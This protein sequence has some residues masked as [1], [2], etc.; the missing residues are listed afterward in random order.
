M[1]FSLGSTTVGFMECSYLL[2]DVIKTEERG[3]LT[4]P[5]KRDQIMSLATELMRHK[6]LY[7]RGTPEISD[8]A[9][10]S[11]EMKL[12]KLS[13]NHPVLSFVGTDSPITTKKVSHGKAMLSLQKTYDLHD[14]RA[15]IGQ[16]AVVGTWKIDGNSLSLVYQQGK[17]VLA[18]TRG[19]GKFGE[20]V[21]DKIRWVAD[22]IPT[23]PDKLDIEIRGELYCSAE[24]FHLLAKEMTDLGM[25]KPTHPRNI[26]SGMLGRKNDYHLARYFN[27]QAFELIDETDSLVLESEMMCFRWLQ[28]QGFR[29]PGVQLLINQEATSIYLNQVRHL[30]TTGDI[31]IDGAVFSINDR[32]LHQKLGYTAHHPRYKMVFK[33]QGETAISTIE[34]IEWSTSRLGIVTPV[35]VIKPVFLSGAKIKNITLHNAQHIINF[36]LKPGDQIE[37]VRSGEVIPKFLRV[38]KS[39][40]GKHQLP[41]ACPS[42]QNTLHFDGIRLKCLNDHCPA[43][44]TGE[45]LNWIKAVEIDDLSEKRLQHLLDRKLI[46]NIPDLYRLTESDF[47]KLPLTKEKM[48]RKLVSAIAKSRNLPLVHFLNGL[49]FEGMG[50]TS[51]LALLKAFPTLTELRKCSAEEIGKQNGFAEKTAEQIVKDFKKKAS[52]IDHLLQIGV[53]PFSENGPSSTKTLEDKNIVITGKLS[54][55]RKKIE[56]LIRH[57]GGKPMSAISTHTDILV[58]N[59]LQTHSTKKW[60]KAISLGIK[61]WNEQELMTFIQENKG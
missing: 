6:R 30:M 15:W 36:N 61:I 20:D 45:I 32:K 31:G 59:D 10:D 27:F 7:Y 29:I 49:G 51:W 16:H 26:V 22:I 14:L 19:D 3:I 60:Q 50:T 43:I 58:A 46:A 57:E 42:C 48:A 11:L 18:K 9:Y 4:K 12:K 13:P 33:W 56:E 47:L 38:E 54:Q 1:L 5:E 41:T 52:L 24:N 35:A 8:D 28:D 39:S 40:S 2:K 21:T 23:L 44:I 53:T 34:N 17:M 37:I 25:E 55:P